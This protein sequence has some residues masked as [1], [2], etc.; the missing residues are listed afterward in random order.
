[1]TQ[2]TINDGMG[3]QIVTDYAYQNPAM[4]GEYNQYGTL[5]ASEFLGFK[6]STAHHFE[7]VAEGATPNQEA[8]YEEMTFWQAAPSAAS[9]PKPRDPRTGKMQ[10]HRIWSNLLTNGAQC[11]EW[12]RPSKDQPRCLL[13]EST[14]VWVAYRLTNNVWTTWVN[15]QTGP[16]GVR[17]ETDNEIKD[18]ASNSTTYLYDLA[19]QNGGQFGNVTQV[20]ESADGALLRTT[21]T[22]YFPNAAANIVNKPARVRVYQGAFDATAPLNN[23]L[24][25][26]RTIYDNM[27]ID[28]NSP[29]S[30][31][32]V[33]KTQ[34]A[35]TAC[36][37]ATTIGMYDANWQETRMAYDSHGNQTNLHHVGASATEGND[38]LHTAYDDYYQLFPIRQEKG[39]NPAF[40]ETAAY[41]GVNGNGPDNAPYGTNSASASD[42][43]AYWGAMAEHCAV[44]EVCTRQAYDNFGRPTLRWDN[45]PRGNAWDTDANASVLW[46]Y[47][48]P[49]MNAGFKTTVVTEAH[50]PRCEG[51]F[52]RKHYNGLG[53]LVAEQKPD[54][55]WTWTADDCTLPTQLKEIETLYAYN[56]LGQQT[57]ASVPYR[58]TENWVSRIAAVK[59][60]TV[61]NSIPNTAIVYDPLGRP[62]RSIAPND[63]FTL[64]D[65][66]R[67]AS[68]SKTKERTKSDNDPD[69]YRAN[70]WKE[71]DGLGN[72]ANIRTWTYIGQ[73]PNRPPRDPWVETTRVNFTHDATGNLTKVEHPIGLGIGTTTMTYDLLGHKTSMNDVD[74]GHWTYAYD[75][76]GKLTSQTDA[77]GNLTVLTYENVFAQVNGKLFQKGR[78]CFYVIAPQYNVTF[79]YG[80]AG[81]SR[82]RLTKVRY[83]DGSYQKDIGYDGLGLLSSETVKID[84]APQSYT[85]IMVTMSI[86]ARM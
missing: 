13:A 62:T 59:W 33:A 55:D 73:D 38:W 7:I 15:E 29:P 20:Q 76:Q 1:M 60:N 80:Q 10:L 47:R 64:Y 78:N 12:E 68:T 9:A 14:P 6:D 57:R 50:A 44:N 86:N 51:N 71:L 11:P 83:T 45:V 25:E 85:P 70:W 26:T 42:P 82:R 24:A 72:V 23:C 31:G 54:Q 22:E 18:G 46:T 4:R 49:K 8:Q 41:Y 16:F 66:L 56:A 39:Q 67:R 63:E 40:A 21:V 30:K 65:Y 74:M 34:Q 52:V 61:W 17:K 28:Y 2:T 3:N 32:L 5:T 48:N 43:K 36:A 27:E 58:A 19:Q 79:L 69:A 77:C 35:I 53:Q 84:G 75:R 37:S 81:V